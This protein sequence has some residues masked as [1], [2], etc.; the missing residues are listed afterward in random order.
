[1]RYKEPFMEIIELE[2]NDVVTISSEENLNPSLE[3]TEDG[4][5]L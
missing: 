2:V 1:M 4:G 5:F 3:K